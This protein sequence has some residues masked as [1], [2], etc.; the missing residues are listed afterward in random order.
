M[1][2]LFNLLRALFCSNSTVSP[3]YLEFV[4]KSN[5]NWFN[6]LHYSAISSLIFLFFEITMDFSYH[7]DST[8]L[9]LSSK[10]LIYLTIFTPSLMILITKVCFDLNNLNFFRFKT[11]NTVISTIFTTFLVII[12]LLKLELIQKKNQEFSLENQLEIFMGTMLFFVFYLIFWVLIQNFRVKLLLLI[13]HNI[14]MIF[15][16]I[17]IMKLASFYVVKLIATLVLISIFMVIYS[18]YREKQIYDCFFAKKQSETIQ[19]DWKNI[20]NDFP[21][22]VIL[23]SLKKRI[24]YLNKSINDLF[25]LKNNELITSFDK[26]SEN[27]R[28]KLLD[29]ASYQNLV[30]KIGKIEEINPF[31]ESLEESGQQIGGEN[32]QIEG[33]S[34]LE[35]SD[36]GSNS[37]NM[38]PQN[39]KKSILGFNP[40]NIITTHSS[41][42]NL[43]QY[44]ASS[45]KLKSS[46]F[47]SLQCKSN[48]VSPCNNDF[49]N[50]NEKMKKKSME[51]NDTST[52]KVDLSQKEY[53]LNDVVNSIRNKM[54]QEKNTNL[55][56]STLKTQIPL[57]TY[58][59]QYKHCKNN[60]K[61]KKYELKIKLI[62]YK[63]E[64]VFLIIVQDVSYL[65]LVQELREN[66]DYKTKV[67]TTLS[68]E[69]RTPLNGAITPL[70][71]LL[72]EQDLQIK[73]LE[74]FKEVD[75]A[76]KSMIL[77][78]SVLNDVVDYALINSNQLCLNYEEMNFFQFLR[79]TLDLF[80]QQ[81]EEKK[82][83]IMLI[84]DQ[85]KKLP[86]IFKTDFQRLRQ[87]LVSLLNNSMKNTF[88]GSIKLKINLVKP[89]YETQN[90]TFNIKE[91][92]DFSPKKGKSFT[93]MTKKTR[94]LKEKPFFASSH[95]KKYVLKLSV[96]DTGVGIDAKK[97][98]NISKCFILRDL[99]DVCLNLNRK[100]GCGVGLTIS[101]CLSLL[102]GPQDNA[103]LEIKKAI[104]GT[105]VFFY[106]EGYVEK[107]KE[108]LSIIEENKQE[109]SKYSTFRQNSMYAASK[110]S[111][112][113]AMKTNNSS[114]LLNKKREKSKGSMNLAISESEMVIDFDGSLKENSGSNRT[115]RIF[116]EKS[117]KTELYEIDGKYISQFVEGHHFQTH[118]DTL[119][120]NKVSFLQ[121]SKENLTN[122]E[123]NG[124][125]GCFCE[126]IL[127]VDDDSFNILALEAIL[128]KFSLKVVKAFN[129]QQAID[130]IIK[131]NK[132][133]CG[134]KCCLFPLIFLDY[135]MPIKDG[136]ETTIEIKEMVKKDIIPEFPIIAC[137]AFGAKSLVENWAAAGMSDFVIKPINFEKM[138]RIL[139]KW[140]V[141]V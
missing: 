15:F 75:I 2:S 84:F 61:S 29:K 94:K 105:E 6:L 133:K 122:N 86:K 48:D 98:K 24:I 85:T 28:K 8:L 5:T 38:T 83:D 65:D 112:Y 123:K 131:K 81:A 45:S 79:D 30:E 71:K 90:T 20:L 42:L 26:N 50:N 108:D 107:D 58:C 134:E 56:S 36:L 100:T 52:Q 37:M 41:P 119:S 60:Q 88:E 110:S 138:E 125:N 35:S 3:M 14:T 4:S 44:S 74:I 66:N 82:I 73:D 128:S 18:A 21:N 47:I 55:L 31:K 7:Y 95:L 77:L 34:I 106:L 76:F 129:G 63:N 39:K 101:H 12:L 54:K 78:Q 132:E 1:K 109:T 114:E 130:I 92:E 17:F 91:K 9:I 40:V 87:I 104:N 62:L 57:K 140:K 19:E 67:L 59:T 13:L 136:V 120:L 33:F 68:H 43:H 135:H 25:E 46:D 113:Y 137:T 27:E 97:L 64:T 126:E 111:A 127:V 117:Q 72:K 10:I 32:R 16:A 53:T 102:L 99:L 115:N 49:L 89:S 141:V 118:S 139:R 124:E 11:V 93:E 80:T 69:L 96:E 121:N 51:N 22:G 23:L 70:E 116:S 103:G